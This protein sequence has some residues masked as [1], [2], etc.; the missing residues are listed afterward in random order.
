M[1]VRL[2]KEKTIKDFIAGNSGSKAS[3]DE[4]LSLSIE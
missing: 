2:I 1:K 4:W 3:F